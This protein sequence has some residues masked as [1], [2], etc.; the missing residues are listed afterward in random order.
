MENEITAYL[1]LLSKLKAKRQ[2]ARP[3]EVGCEVTLANGQK[4]IISKIV[5]DE[6]QGENAFYR[7]NVNIPYEIEHAAM[8]GSKLE[9]VDVSWK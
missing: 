9:I 6:A 1:D 8:Y 7:W 4:Q 2:S 5:Y 3:L